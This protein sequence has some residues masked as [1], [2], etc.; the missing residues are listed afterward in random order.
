MNSRPLNRIGAKWQEC[1][2]S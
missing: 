2:A 1:T